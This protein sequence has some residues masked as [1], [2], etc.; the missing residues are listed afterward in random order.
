MAKRKAGSQIVS[1]TLDD[2]FLS[3]LLDPLE[4]P[5]TLNCGKFGFEGRSRLPALKGGRGAC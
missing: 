1:L 2:A 5:S 3:P 4:G